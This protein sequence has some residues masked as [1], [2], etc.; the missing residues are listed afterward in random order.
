[1]P[2][3]KSTSKPSFTA[4]MFTSTSFRTAE[5][6][7]W[8]ANALADFITKHKFNRN[9]F[10]KRLYEYLS[11]AF[12]HIAHT[13]IDGFYEAWFATLSQQT[14]FLRLMHS[15]TP[16]G[17]PKYTF[18]D[19]ERELVSWVRQNDLHSKHYRQLMVDVMNREVALMFELI[20]KQGIQ[21]GVKVE[22]PEIMPPEHSMQYAFA[23]GRCDFNHNRNSERADE[24]WMTAYKAGRKYAEFTKHS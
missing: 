8:F 7:A 23:C 5:D 17:D 19:V 20:A 14:E 16:M 3:T 12:G 1:M 10:T 4:S 9:K 13:N 15:Y 11:N 21:R 2:S 18:S 22:K 24:N 6:K